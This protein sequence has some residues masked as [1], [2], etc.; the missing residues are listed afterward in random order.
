MREVVRHPRTV[1]GS[2]REASGSPWKYVELLASAQRCCLGPTH[3]VGMVAGCV[4][5]VLC[6]S[7]RYCALASHPFT[8]A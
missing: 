2:C 7:V 4:I 6:V 1:K 8:R 3:P 5:W